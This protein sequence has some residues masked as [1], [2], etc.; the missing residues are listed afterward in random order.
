M[1]AVISYLPYQGWMLQSSKRRPH[2]CHGLPHPSMWP[3]T[4][5]WHLEPLLAG[6]DGSPHLHLSHE[7]QVR[8]RPR[9]VHGGL[10]GLLHRRGI[11][12]LS[13]RVPHPIVRGPC[14]HLPAA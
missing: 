12:R 14:E 6:K 11:L 10:G 4:C 13:S 8:Q 3:L 7:R 5:Y 2:P 9:R 1:L